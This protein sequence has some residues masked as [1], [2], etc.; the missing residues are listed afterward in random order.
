MRMTVFDTPVICWVAR[1]L[2]WAF[3]RV[4]GWEKEGHLPDEPKYV[5]IGAPHTSN[6]DV[7]FVLSLAF[8]YR[9]K[10][11]F[12]AKDSVFRWPFGWFFRWLG[13]IPVD[14]SKPNGMVAQT[15]EVFNQNERLV[16][17]IPPEGTRK[18]V[19]QWKTGFYWIA[20]GAK[21]PIALGFMDFKRKRGGP[22]PLFWPTG[23]IEK[24]MKEIQD[25]YSNVTPLYPE[26]SGR[27]EIPVSASHKDEK[28][29][30][31]S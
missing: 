11:F 5:L 31:G 2:A 29:E 16:I 30:K 27:S 18:R 8:A 10:I 4:N 26:L 1:A 3:L 28:E 20:Y 6:W 7:P 25:F 15:I 17:C 24:D 21:I 22:G 19:R 23:D 14:R 9:I 13:G 12:M